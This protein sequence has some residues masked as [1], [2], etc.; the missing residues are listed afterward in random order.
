LNNKLLAE[1][2][3][4]ERRL[5][6]TE[7]GT[8]TAIVDSPFFA[9]SCAC[10]YNAAYFDASDPQERNNRQV[11]GNITGFWNLAGRHDTKAGY[12]F[13]RSQLIGGNSQS[14]TSYVFNADFVTDGSGRP[15]RD[16]GGRL[17]PVFEPGESILENFAAVRGAELNIDNH[18]IYVK[19]HWAV[20]NR[21]SFD[22]GARF[23][24]V[25]SSAAGD[26]V[27][28]NTW[29]MV[30]RL[31]AAYDLLGE[32]NHIVHVTYGQ[33]SGRYTETQIRVNSPVGNPA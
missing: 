25:K 18:S 3:Y 32:S 15:V 16:A 2:Q 23:E 31:A 9:L 4:S 24:R 7:G 26:I 14:S 19:D 11:T 1:A 27:G 17:I 33:Y 12:E 5:D 6:L 22:L 30:P 13:F 20:N 10:I 21:W 29:R 8:S 28:V